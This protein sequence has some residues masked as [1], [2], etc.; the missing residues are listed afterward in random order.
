[1]TGWLP[2]DR[3]RKGLNGPCAVDTLAIACHAW[4]ESLHDPVIRQ[5]LETY[6]RPPDEM[7]IEWICKVD[8]LT[9][10][11]P[12]YSVDLQ[13]HWVL[14]WWPLTDLPPWLPWWARAV[15]W[16]MDLTGTTDR[17]A[18]DYDRRPADEGPGAR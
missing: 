8:S 4:G 6:G 11:G 17:R 16:W 9:Y 18:D 2:P 14:T 15:N 10:I 12:G 7:T 3:T 13:L 5:S 1:M